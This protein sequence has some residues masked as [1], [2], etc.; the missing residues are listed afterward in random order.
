MWVD[1]MQESGFEVVTHDL[2]DLSIINL[3]FPLPGDII[4]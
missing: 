1:H 4:P 3:R 2:D